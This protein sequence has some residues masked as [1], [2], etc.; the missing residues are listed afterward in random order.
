MALRTF[1]MKV[2]LHDEQFDGVMHAACA[3]VD[4]AT[5]KI[6]TSDEFGRIPPA[7][8]CR[9]CERYEW[10]HGGA[11]NQPLTSAG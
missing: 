1:G 7:S 8:R 3:R 5:G 9:Y 10:P 6:V 4:D 2:H 11:P